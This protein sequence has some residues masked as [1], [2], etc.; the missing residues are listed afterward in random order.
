M[1]EQ[2]ARLEVL[3]RLVVPDLWP[4]VTRR[5]QG[6]RPPRAPSP[7]RRAAIAAVA[8]LVAGLSFL[9]LVRLWPDRGHRPATSPTPSVA[10]PVDNGPIY[11]RSQARGDVIPTAWE[12]VSPSGTGLHTIFPASGPFVPDHMAFSPEGTRIVADL[13]DRPGIWVADPDG[14]HAVQLTQGAN[15]AWPVWSPDGTKIAFAG[16]TVSTPCP[17]SESEYGCRRDLY[18]MN[19]DGTGLRLIAK[20]AAAPSWSPH[21]QR[22]AF[23]T[24]GRGAGMTSI[25][26]VNADGTGERIVAST[27]RGSDF[28]PAWSPDGSTIVYASIRNE[29]WGIFA[30]PA[31]GGAEQILR[32]ARPATDYVDDPTWSPD[33]RLIAFVAGD[34]IS[35]MRPDGSHIRS[36]FRQRTRFPAGS[37]AWQ[38]IPR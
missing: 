1:P 10:V 13:V 26:I 19:N 34:G 21:G 30:V 36:I 4:E 5:R 7:L 37:I 17:P 20:N 18:V 6:S 16:S 3:D 9:A 14:R 23:D 31:A 12:A 28:A 35:I 15:D 24:S 2:P 22:I 25:G 33:G 11:F 29:N 32:P 8:L 38:P 27:S